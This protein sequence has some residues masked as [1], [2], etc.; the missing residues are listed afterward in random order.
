MGFM[1]SGWILLKKVGER[2]LREAFAEKEIE[3]RN[4][5]LASK[6]TKTK[7]DSCVFAEVALPFQSFVKLP[8]FPS[9]F[10]FV[11]I[12]HCFYLLL[13]LPSKGERSLRDLS[14]L[15]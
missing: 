2:D 6:L 3:C 15:H 7:D 10:I 5:N 13:I 11:E 1:G 8:L 4:K 12:Y 14:R 9:K